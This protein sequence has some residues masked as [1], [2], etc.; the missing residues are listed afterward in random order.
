MHLPFFSRCW[1]LRSRRAHVSRHWITRLLLSATM[2]LWSGE[3]SAL[4]SSRYFLRGLIL[5]HLQAM[6]RERIHKLWSPRRIRLVPCLYTEMMFTV[7]FH[8]SPALSAFRMWIWT[9]TRKQA[10]VLG[11]GWEEQPGA[12]VLGWDGPYLHHAF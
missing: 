1:N 8:Q 2:P 4:P 11:H 10:G 12:Q 5:G 7:N 3:S 9:A 6:S